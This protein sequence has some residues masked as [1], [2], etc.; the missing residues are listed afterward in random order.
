[1]TN[2]IQKKLTDEQ[3][4]YLQAL[5]VDVVNLPE[6]YDKVSLFDY[7]NKLLSAI[8]DALGTP[9]P[10][11]QVVLT[12]TESVIEDLDLLINKDD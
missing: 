5:G 4:D 10:T 12:A 6:V 7:I 11:Y 1:M 9:R 8:T 2:M 3:R